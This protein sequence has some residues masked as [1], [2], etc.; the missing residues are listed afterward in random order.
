MAAGA[1]EQHRCGLRSVAIPP[2][3]RLVAGLRD[4]S[5]VSPAWEGHFSD[6]LVPQGLSVRL[7]CRNRLLPCCPASEG[8]PN[9]CRTFAGEQTSPLPRT[10]PSPACG[11]RTRPSSGRRPQGPGKVTSGRVPTTSACG[12][13]PSGPPPL[14]PLDDFAGSLKASGHPERLLTSLFGRRII[15]ICPFFQVS[16]FTS[17]ADGLLRRWISPR[18]FL[19]PS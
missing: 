1:G 15:H 16:A 18:A 7:R 8:V 4:N 14:G 12:S 2:G 13:G 11:S 17:Q 9:M 6:S 10:G 3:I 19:S 5:G